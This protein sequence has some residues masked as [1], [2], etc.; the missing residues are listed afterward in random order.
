MTLPFLSLIIAFDAICL[1]PAAAQQDPD[2]PSC[3]ILNPKTASDIAAKIAGCTRVLDR[4]GSQTAHSRAIALAN[5]GQAYQNGGN[6]DRAIADFSEA[7]RIDADFPNWRYARAVQYGNR[8]ELD[9]AIADFSE[10]IRLKPNVAGYLSQRGRAYEQIGD[11][12]KALIDFKAALTLDPNTPDVGAAV[13][14]VEQ[15]LAAIS[16]KPAVSAPAPQTYRMII[17]SHPDAGA[18]CL[19]ISNSQFVEGARLQTSDCLPATGQIFTYNEATQLLTI[20]GLCI[21]LG[22]GGKEAAAVSLGSC[23]GQPNQ[24]WRV[25]ANGEYYRFIGTNGQCLDNA[26]LLNV[27][28]C[29]VQLT[30]QL[31]ALVS[32]GDGI[33][34]P[35]AAST[36]STPPNNSSDVAPLA[37]AP[38]SAAS[39]QPVCHQEAWHAA[40]LY[41]ETASANQTI[42]GGAT[43]IIHLQSGLDSPY[44]TIASPPKNGILSLLDPLTLKYQPNPGFRGSD[45][46]IFH[47]CGSDNKSGRSGCSTVTYNVTAN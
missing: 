4:A 23:T 17:Q 35:Q 22:G 19:N 28:N 40:S 12:A 26:N 15:K 34:Q 39:P 47:L 1:V 44:A 18:K 33:G 7:I 25:V 21:G 46:Y 36:T 14:R 16:T 11:P 6:L 20:G 42:T 38:P 45:Q 37:A 30:T 13:S 24:R 10:A 9:L 29:G 3:N 32:P 8:G 27:Q 5:R 31:W 41:N 43:C 2:W